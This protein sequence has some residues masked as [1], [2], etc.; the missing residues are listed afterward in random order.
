MSPPLPPPHKRD[1]AMTLGTIH[2]NGIH[3]LV[4]TLVGIV[5]LLAG[6][7]MRVSSIVTS[8]S[9][10]RDRGVALEARLDAKLDGLEQAMRDVQAELR[11]LR[12]SRE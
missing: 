7:E 4:A 9:Y 1:L 10:P 8:Q 2:L 5:S 11:A 6:M 3:L 12:H